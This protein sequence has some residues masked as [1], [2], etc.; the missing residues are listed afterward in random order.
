[1]FSKHDPNIHVNAS[2]RETD[3]SEV[4]E[5]A[6]LIALTFEEQEQDQPGLHADSA[7]DSTVNQRISAS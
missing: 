5:A 3:R 4:V 1:V 7:T 2:Q 6:G